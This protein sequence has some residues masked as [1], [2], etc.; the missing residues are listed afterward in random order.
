MDKLKLKNK[1][2]TVDLP[3]DVHAQLKARCAL[4]GTKMVDVIR[5]LVQL[6]LTQR[7]SESDKSGPAG[8]RHDPNR[9]GY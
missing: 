2:L 9:A 4:D 6:F 7:S 3:P 1:R 8:Q 5:T